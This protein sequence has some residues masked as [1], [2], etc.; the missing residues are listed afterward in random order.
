MIRALGDSCESS[1]D[2][3]GLVHSQIVKIVYKAAFG[4]MKDEVEVKLINLL[5]NYTNVL[6]VFGVG[7]YVPWLSWVDQV[8]GLE[9]KTKKAAKEFDEFLEGVIEEHVNQDGM[10]HSRIIN[11]GQTFIEVLLNANKD[12]TMGFT[13][14]K[15]VVKAILLVIY[16]EKYQCRSY[17]FKKCSNVGYMVTGYSRVQSLKL[18]NVN[19]VEMW[20]TISS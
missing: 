1:V 11:E 8:T 7:S 3:G 16:S 17:T 18:T 15:D 19:K 20:D 14:D 5:N 6:M 4:R 2:I 9:G 13:I 10:E 12:V